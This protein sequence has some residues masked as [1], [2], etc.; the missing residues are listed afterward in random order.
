[1]PSAR[2]LRLAG[3]ISALVIFVQLNVLAGRFFRR[4]D[5]TSD[6]LYTLSDVTQQTLD[7][8]NEPID[9]VVF[10]S[11]SDPL[12]ASVITLLDAYRSRS[13]QIRV[14]SVDPDR[15][16]AEFIALQ[17]DYGIFEGKTVDGRLATDASIVTS[18]F[19]RRPSRST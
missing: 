11:R 17:R 9:V 15:N 6:G 12:H 4:W 2:W 18:D 16:P 7:G 5:A 8:L 14:R 10:L 13:S 19:V 3:A 1:M